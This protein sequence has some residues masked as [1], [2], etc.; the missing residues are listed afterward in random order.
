[1]TRSFIFA[2][3]FYCIVG[4]IAFAVYGSY[5]QDSF[6]KNLGRDL[7]L[8]PIPGKAFLYIICSACFFINLQATFPLI[9]MGLIASSEEALGITANRSLRIVW[10][11]LFMAG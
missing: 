8:R 9:A 1:M 2:G 4:L 5:A 7:D 3:L 6:M 10:K 11:A